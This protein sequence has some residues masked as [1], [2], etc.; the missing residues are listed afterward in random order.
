MPIDELRTTLEAART[1]K[2]ALK[3]EK[4]LEH[5]LA[6]EAIAKRLVEESTPL[7]VEAVDAYFVQTALAIGDM[8]L[9]LER[10]F[11]DAVARYLRVKAYPLA[12]PPIG[13][14][15]LWLRL[16]QA[17]LMRGDAAFR[18]DQ[19]AQ[20]QQ[21]YNRVIVRDAAGMAP[22][23]NE[24]YTGV[25]EIMARKVRFWLTTPPADIEQADARDYPP[26][27][28]ATLTEIRRR[29]EH[30]DAGLNFLGYPPDYAPIFSFARLQEVA[31]GFAQFAA[32]ANREYINFMRT[33][34]AEQQTLRQLEQS[35]NLSLAA[36]EI[37][38][39]RVEVV[40]REIEASLDAVR[41][42]EAR[43]QR[44][45]AASDRFGETG[46]Q[47]AQ[48]RAAQAWA[49][50]A[51]VGKEEEIK[52]RY[53]GLSDLGIAERYQPRSELIHNIAW[54]E[55]VRSYGLEAQ[56]YRD[57][58]SDLRE[59]VVL[60]QSQLD[61]SRSR[62]E[63]AELAVTG[64]RWRY[65]DSVETLQAAR[66]QA[67][68]AELMLELAGLARETAGIYLSRAI[69]AAFLMQQAF[70]LENNV[71]TG[72]VRLDYGDLLVADGLYAADLL[73]RDIDEFTINS[74]AGVQNKVQSGVHVLSLAQEFPFALSE[75]IRTGETQ[76]ETRLE[77]LHRTLPGTYD[78]RIKRVAVQVFANAGPDGISGAL[79][80]AGVSRVRRAD[81][82]MLSKVHAA[83]TMVLPRATAK[84]NID[85]PV[86]ERTGGPGQLEVFENIGVATSWNLSLPP[87]WNS[88]EFPSLTDVSLVF[89]YWFRHDPALHAADIAAQ[90]DTSE[91][92]QKLNIQNGAPEWT[93]LQ[94]TGVAEL[95][96]DQLVPPHKRVG[97][98]ILTAAIIV[99]RPDGS[100]AEVSVRF[101]ALRS[102][103]SVTARTGA[104]GA[105]MLEDREAPGVL[106]GIPAAQ[107][108]RLSIPPADNPQLA[109]AASGGLD[110]SSIYL[111]Q[112]V[113]EYQ[114]QLRK[115]L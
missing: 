114:Y 100:V 23:D 33:A 77:D 96:F 28:M 58:V 32:Q 95:R 107:R 74:V 42:A 70:R 38:R 14:E 89:A 43:A 39:S 108:F 44:A 109:K 26:R 113:I 3:R 80:C 73:L 93:A 22:P 52:L 68:S 46:W 53:D 76:F 15:A 79:S 94:A 111:V 115:A 31:R 5:F 85:A 88:I 104:D 4:A 45:Q 110:L 25:L 41:V 37:E 35:V 24:F 91:A 7:L 48:L 90:D 6:A 67:I 27:L 51:V 18:R 19:K 99:L 13:A 83:E 54:A 106:A 103:E 2:I 55:S 87:E 17:C 92:V 60:A 105:V 34:Q 75:L 82:G 12:D 40:E 49:G 61:A 101:E 63:A 72:R 112:V 1:A 62:R 21:V 84:R 16:A 78:G 81:G 71:R 56:R 86:P 9:E 36:V 20:A 64:A 30:L 69:E 59:G 97:A 11:D 102:G 98:A 47:L 10:N 57:A 66:E 8:L 29:L 65:R 50:A